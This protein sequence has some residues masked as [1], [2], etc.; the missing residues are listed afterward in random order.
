M[1]V[2][3]QNVSEITVGYKSTDRVKPVVKTSKDAYQELIQWFPED[4]IGLQEMFLVAYLNR[5]NKIIGVYQVSRGG[6]TATVADPRLILATALK[7]A[8]TGIILC[9]NHP[10]GSLR[11]SSLDEELTNKIK[12]GARFMDIMVLDHL[13]VSPDGNFLS[14]ADDG[15][16]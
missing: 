2:L 8:A 6:I 9:H 16:M 15:L 3:S 10:S 5:S 12:Q 7:V 13:I 4:L 14:F 11:P 1:K